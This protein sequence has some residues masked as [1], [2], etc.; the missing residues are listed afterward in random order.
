[1][2][3]E[4][5]GTKKLANGKKVLKTNIPSTIEKR[6]DDIYII[7]Q[8]S[9]RLDLLANQFYNDSRLW[10]IIAQANVIIEA[11]PLVDDIEIE[12]NKDKIKGEALFLRAIMHFELLR[13]FGNPNLDLGVPLI[14]EAPSVDDMPARASI[15]DCS[16]R[17][18]AQTK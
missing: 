14:L 5:V 4:K 18:T 2:R 15:E 8:D 17:S 3:Y 12:A 10:W 9:D 16:G 6:D 1:M 7:T 11:I 13:N